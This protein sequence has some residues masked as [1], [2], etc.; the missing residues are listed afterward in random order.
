MEKGKPKGGSVKEQEAPVAQW[1]IM[2]HTHAC[3]LLVTGVLS[4]CAEE[5]AGMDGDARKS[6]SY[7][8]L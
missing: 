8:P 2:Q 7:D 5:G 3:N 4:L 6:I 1:S